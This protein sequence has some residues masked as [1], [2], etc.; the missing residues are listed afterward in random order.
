MILHRH[1]GEVL[2]FQGYTPSRGTMAGG[3]STALVP[4]GAGPQWQIES[5][6]ALPLY[7]FHPGSP[8]LC[9]GRA[10][11]SPFRA[12]EAQ[13]MS[14]DDLMR[15]VDRYGVQSVAF[16]DSPPG[17]GEPFDTTLFEVCQQRGLRMMALTAGAMPAELRK[18]YFQGMQAVSVDLK[19]FTDAFYVQQTGAQLS[20]V[21]ET[22]LHLYH[23][24]E[25]WLEIRT[26]LMPGM[27]DHPI[28]LDA[29]SQWLYKHLGHE[30]PLHFTILPPGNSHHRSSP[31]AF[32]ILNKARKIAEGNGLS[33]VYL[34]HPECPEG[35]NTR[36]ECCSL[37]LMRREG[38]KLVSFDPSIGFECPDCGMKIKGKFPESPIEIPRIDHE[39]GERGP[40]TLSLR[41]EHAG[42]IEFAP[43]R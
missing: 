12:T 28:E 32:T 25:C 9:L 19:A 23:E 34:D 18:A 4:F 10:G 24:T 26:C 36:C 1:G 20:P 3:A 43:F 42:E 15:I 35:S 40:W 41:L 21:L 31:S 39:P 27:N 13:R 11:R 14:P 7:H 17:N 30:V 16:N 6:E 38:G 33:H 2:R 29:M 5:V 37:T 22:L 8:V